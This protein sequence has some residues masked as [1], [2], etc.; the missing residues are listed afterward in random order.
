VTREEVSGPVEGD[1]YAVANLDG[2]G[3]GYGFRKVRRGLRVSAFG[4][5]AIVLPPGYETGRHYH[6]RQEEVYFVHRGRIEVELGDGDVHLLGPGG[7]A[8]IDP[9]TVR[10]VRNVGEEDA[11]YV[12]IGGSGGYVGRDGHLAEGETSRLGEPPGAGDGDR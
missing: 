5:N 7:V 10:R 12:A 11:V 6:E 2:L 1:G 8:R 3:E 9:A 4:I